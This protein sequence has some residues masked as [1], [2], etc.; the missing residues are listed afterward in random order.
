MDIEQLARVWI[1]DV[2]FPIFIACLSIYWLMR[3]FA[4]YEKI[5]ERMGDLAEQSTR[6]LANNIIVTDKNTASVDSLAA[7]MRKFGSDPE[8]WCKSSQTICKASEIAE[9]IKH[10]KSS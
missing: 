7:Q 9:A 10:L 6:T 8:K 5:A 2:G 4:K 1:K 3:F